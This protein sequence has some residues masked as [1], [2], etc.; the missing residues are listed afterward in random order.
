[1]WLDSTGDFAH[2]RVVEFWSFRL[3]IGTGATDYIQ[4]IMGLL[5]AMRPVEGL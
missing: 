2:R 3:D 4:A 1:M 5:G